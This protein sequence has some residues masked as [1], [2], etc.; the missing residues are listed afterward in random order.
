VGPV[1][2][3][4]DEFSSGSHEKAGRRRRRGPF[5]GADR[6]GH[7]DADGTVVAKDEGMRRGTTVEKLAGAQARRSRRTA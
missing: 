5:D 4:L 2:Q 7:A 3:Q 6:P 1:P